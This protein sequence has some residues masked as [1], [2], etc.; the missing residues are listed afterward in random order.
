[1][2][3]EK[4]LFYTGR[5]F[6]EFARGRLESAKQAVGRIPPDRLLYED[7]DVLFEEI[8]KKF[9]VQPLVLRPDQ[10]RATDPRQVKI[11]IGELSDAWT[12]PAMS[13]YGPQH[14]IEGTEIE[15]H[16]PFDGTREL[17]DVS[18]SSFSPNPPSGAIVGEELLLVFR[19]IDAPNWPQIDA[20]VQARL[21][22]IAGWLKNLN[23]EIEQSQ[24][25]FRQEVY[26]TINAAHSVQ[27]QAMRERERLGYGRISIQPIVS[28][29]TRGAAKLDVVMQERL[30]RDGLP[31]E[32]FEQIL[33]TIRRFSKQME[34][35]PM[36]LASLG[37]EDLRALYLGTLNAL[38]PGAATGETFNGRGKTD[39]MV[40]A[41]DDILAIAECKIWKGPAG[42]TEAVDQLLGYLIWRNQAAAVV[43]FNKNL[44]HAAVFNQIP[45][46]LEARPDVLNVQRDD[47]PA[48]VRCSLKHPKRSDHPLHLSVLVVHLP[49]S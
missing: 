13:I 34:R 49:N 28:R 41:G 22:Q 2:A 24:V 14:L 15:I 21:L 45:T 11:R 10:K 16:I 27:I 9:G 36:V 18:P 17:W 5:W 47:D 48:L 31:A 7:G 44:D 32:Q 19:S 4:P 6:A 20:Q 42:F 39:I 30:D 25:G 38:S 35:M 8:E 46:L 33:Q 37:E 29:L 3:Q 43:M 40:R 12:R 26:G 1:M 23:P